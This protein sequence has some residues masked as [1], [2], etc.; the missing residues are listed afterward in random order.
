MVVFVGS[1]TAWCHP[2]LYQRIMKVKEERDL[3][4]F[5]IDP[6]F[7]ATCEAADLHLTDFTGSRCYFVQWS[8]TVFA[9]NHYTDTILLQS[10]LWARASAGK[11]RI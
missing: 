3:L 8:I 11:Q 1:N 2:V 9:T 6:R 10:I 4:S 5:V 7:T